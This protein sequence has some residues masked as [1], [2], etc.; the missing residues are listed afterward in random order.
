M[1]A[2]KLCKVRAEK[3][4]PN[5]NRVSH[6]VYLPEGEPIPG[7]VWTRVMDDHSVK[8]EHPYVIMK[9]L[10]DIEKSKG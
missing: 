1:S 7:I 2:Y 3:L 9:V 8:A 6:M 5:G 4:D 10:I